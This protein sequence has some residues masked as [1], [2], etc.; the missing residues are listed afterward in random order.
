MSGASKDRTTR[1]G[2]RSGGRRGC[3]C[4]AGPSSFRLRTR[5]P[6]LRPRGTGWGLPSPAGGP[7]CGSS[8]R[9][10]RSRCPPAPS[11]RPSARSCP[12]GPGGRRPRQEPVRA[13]DAHD[14]PAGRGACL[15]RRDPCRV[16]PGIWPEKRGVQLLARRRGAQGA[17]RVVW[18]VL[19]RP[20]D[21]RRPRGS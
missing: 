21:G 1:S 10:P 2:A 15:V 7:P 16:K 14:L 9:G 20:A 4:R 19:A 6:A 3:S 17:R 13:R 12:K 11:L 8:R 5:F 18:P